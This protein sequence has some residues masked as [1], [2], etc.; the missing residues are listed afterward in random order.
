MDAGAPG[1]LSIIG[2]DKYLEHNF[3]ARQNGHMKRSQRL[4]RIL[5]PRD[6]S[7][8]KRRPNVF[9]AKYA[10]RIWGPDCPARVAES[11]SRIPLSGSLDSALSTSKKAWAYTVDPQRVR[12][13][14]LSSELGSDRVQSGLWIAHDA[15]SLSPAQGGNRMTGRQTPN[16]S[17][18]VRLGLG[19]CWGAK[20]WRAQKRRMALSMSRAVALLTRCSS[21]AHPAGNNKVLNDLCPCHQEP[22]RS[23][24]VAS[25]ATVWRHTRR[26]LTLDP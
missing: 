4:A 25:R 26:R 14:L 23:R 17:A 22:V 9:D 2:A 24:W 16:R 18:E 21:K 3:R 20:A 15:V 5:S 12:A 8:C 10:H 6:K 1:R 13:P 19:G 7:S 11:S